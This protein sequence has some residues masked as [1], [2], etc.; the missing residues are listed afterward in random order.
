MTD[1][2]GEMMPYCHVPRKDDDRKAECDPSLALVPDEGA[3]RAALR[4]IEQGRD[5]GHNWHS[6]G[7]CQWCLVALG[8][9]YGITVPPLD[10]K[11]L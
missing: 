11:E 5:N 1:E 6:H 9:S 10:W 2:R 4:F 8:R 7:W 3:R